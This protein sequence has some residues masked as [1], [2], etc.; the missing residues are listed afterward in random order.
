MAN[1][2]TLNGHAPL[3]V[4]VHTADYILTADDSGTAHSSKGAAGA[5]AAKLPAATPGLRFTFYVGAAQEHRVTPLIAEQVCATATDVAG[6]AGKYISAD[7]I[8]ETLQI[9]C[10]EA[11]IWTNLA[12]GGTWT[13]QA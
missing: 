5:I 4:A 1:N 8:G 11:G 9:A 6:T 13:V 10:F 12:S 2:E 7:A 3:E